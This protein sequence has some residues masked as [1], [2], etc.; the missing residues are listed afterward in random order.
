MADS[1]P[2]RSARPALTHRAKAALARLE[3]AGLKRRC[4]DITD[5][6]GPRYRLDGAQVIGFCSNDYLGL[7]HASAERTPAR[8]DSPAGATGS[9]LICGRSEIHREVEAR[10]AQLAG[11]QDAVLFPSAFQANLGVL[12]LVLGPEDRIYSDRLNHAS[13]ID[14]LRLARR[15]LEIID[16]L[17]A[18][19]VDADRPTWWITE[20]LYS[21]NGTQPAPEDID[22]FVHAGGWLCLDDAHAFGLYFGGRGYAS[23]LSRAPE[24]T[25][26]GFGKAIGRAGGAVAADAETCAWIR[27][28]ARS[29][30]FSTAVS[31]R[32]A[33][34]ILHALD[35]VSSKE[36]E[37]RRARLGRNIA[38][39][40]A[41]LGR[42][43]DA[44][45]L[46]PIVPLWVGDNQRALDWSRALLDRGIHVQ[47]IR[48]PTVP[49]GEA[50]LRL[51]LSAAHDSAD[52]GQLLTHLETSA[53]AC[54]IVWPPPAD[55]PQAA[56]SN[57]PDRS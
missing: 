11:T 52:I 38:R 33:A 30:V 13:T 7:A 48:P 6:D 5:R 23:Q 56:V 28:A 8:L 1:D 32:I 14:A 42:S 53:T 12:P 17:Q 34:D 22:A 36:G 4:P 10:V 37:R 40:N 39:V 2:K 57:A 41:T 16:H 18:P 35:L 44:R 21:M 45:H 9:Q 27:S 26:I 51:T 24:L 25:I 49:V 55:K 20:S 54:G 47:A 15:P 46:R 3:H 43:S 29:F 31:P 50:R 19:R